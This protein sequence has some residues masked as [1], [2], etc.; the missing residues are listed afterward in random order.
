M[1]LNLPLVPTPTVKKSHITLPQ[2]IKKINPHAVANDPK[3]NGKN[4]GGNIK[5]SIRRSGP[6]G[7]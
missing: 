6:R 5:S 2:P 1:P 3:G 7:R 4:F